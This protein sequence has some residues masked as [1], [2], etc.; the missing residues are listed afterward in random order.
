MTQSHGGEAP[1]EWPGNLEKMKKNE[2]TLIFFFMFLFYFTARPL[3]KSH[4]T[5]RSGNSCNG[6]VFYFPFLSKHKNTR[7]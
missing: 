7:F 5:R 2:G 1:V 6:G 4:F 3:L